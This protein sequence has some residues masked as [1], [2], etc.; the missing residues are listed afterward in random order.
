MRNTPTYKVPTMRSSTV[1]LLLSAIIAAFS[2]AA[3]AG[4]IYVVCSAGVTLQPGE[5]RDVFLGEKGFA[6]STKLTPA[7]NSAAQAAFLDKVLKLDAV[8]YAGI[9]TKKSF[10]D[11]ANPPPVKS[12]DAEAIAFVKATPGGCSYV[13]SEP[14]GVTVVAKF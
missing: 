12:S 9:W 6:G 4:D 8:K 3:S 13:T 1:A 14:A 2:G 10:R 5:V 11:G 7:D